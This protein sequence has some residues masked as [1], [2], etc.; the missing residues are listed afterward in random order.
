[1]IK[2]INKNILLIYFT[3]LVSIIFAEFFLKID[4]NSVLDIKK[5][6]EDDKIIVNYDNF[7]YE[8]T[9]LGNQLRPGIYNH[10]KKDSDEFI[11]NQNYKINNGN[12]RMNKLIENSNDKALK[13]SFFGGS[14]IFG[15]G[16]NENETLPYLFYEQNK[17]Y[18]VFNYGII[19]GAINQNL[20]MI[21]KNNNYLGDVNVIVT[22]SYQLPRIACNRDYSFN[23]PTFKIINNE[24]K[25]DG[26]CIFSF[27][28]LNFQVPRIIGSIIN[29]SETIKLLNKVFTNE[30]NREN[31]RIYSEIIREI[32]KITDKN[33]KDLIILYYGSDSKIDKEIISFLVKNKILHIDVSLKNKRFFIKHDRHFNK[34]ANEMWLNKLNKFLVTLK[35]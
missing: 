5:K 31:I 32:K 2:K 3:F 22:S 14:D 12:F 26:Y 10:Y 35:P 29:R 4:F 25:F 15:W 27:L 11:F 30:I 13:A 17:D 18:N 23:A 28:N 19:G 7:R 34:L 24:L 9:Y 8:K 33:N 1:M 21:R 6:T 20:E 16:L